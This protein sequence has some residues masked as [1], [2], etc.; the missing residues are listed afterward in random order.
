MFARACDSDA[1]ANP[2]R[3]RFAQYYGWKRVAT[4]HV[5]SFGA[6]SMV[7]DFAALARAA[8]LT[9]V[10]TEILQEGQKESVALENLR[11]KDARIVFVMMFE[12]AFARLICA[13]FRMGMYGQR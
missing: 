6:A 7:N 9:V 13:A 1:A 10:T 3:V 4:V 2:M 8:N 11:R 5:A 12:D